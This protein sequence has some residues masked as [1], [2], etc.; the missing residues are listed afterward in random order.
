MCLV[1]TCKCV[2]KL[3]TVTLLKFLIKHVKLQVKSID[4][5]RLVSSSLDQ[6]IAVWKQDEGKHLKLLRGNCL[7]VC[8]HSTSFGL[9]SG[10][11]QHK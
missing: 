1:C 4:N 6:T 5:H 7:L 8:L 2:Y 3:Q 10:S 11:K 9:F